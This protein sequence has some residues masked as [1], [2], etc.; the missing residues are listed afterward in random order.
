MR[1]AAM[2]KASATIMV[3]DAVFCLKRLKM[4]HTLYAFSV[5]VFICPK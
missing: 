1:A 5:P 3:A 2:I 4:S